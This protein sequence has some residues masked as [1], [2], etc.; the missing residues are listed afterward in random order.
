MAVT[1]E[2]RVRLFRG[3]CQVVGRRAP[4]SLYD[5]GLATYEEG[6]RFQHQAAAGFIHVWSLPTKTW[7]GVTGAAVADTVEV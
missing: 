7:A 2:A 1:G 3:S 5:H 6:D 4:D